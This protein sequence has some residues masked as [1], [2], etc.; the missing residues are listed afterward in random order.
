MVEV[1]KIVFYCY[2]HGSLIAELLQR[3]ESGSVDK[4]SFVI[5]A[6]QKEYY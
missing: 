4:N 6:N 5:V 3:K 2:F 1:V